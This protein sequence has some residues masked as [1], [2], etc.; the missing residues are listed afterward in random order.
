[1]GEGLLILGG[2]LALGAGGAVIYAVASKKPTTAAGPAGPTSG[3]D[4]N[5]WILQGASMNV[6]IGDQVA[7][8][9]NNPPTDVVSFFMQ[10]TQP[11]LAATSGYSN[12]QIY[13]VGNS[14][15]AGW[16]AGDNFGLTAI[17]LSGIATRAISGT[18]TLIPGVAA[19]IWVKPG[20]GVS[21]IH[22]PPAP[23]P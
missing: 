8:A 13:P 1:M 16:P 22:P 7:I 10:F 9:V 6:A 14:K 5:G 23:H 19:S 20:G 12:M 17:R 18:A 4:P 15:P 2:L 3:V 11:A 21:I